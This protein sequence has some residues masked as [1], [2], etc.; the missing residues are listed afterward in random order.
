MIPISGPLS[1]SWARKPRAS[2][3]DPGDAEIIRGV[4]AVNPARAGMI[5]QVDHHYKARTGKP[6]ASGDDPP[7][8][9]PIFRRLM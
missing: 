9:A 7:P 1:A 3:D 8:P 2:G 6:R 5:R 4:D